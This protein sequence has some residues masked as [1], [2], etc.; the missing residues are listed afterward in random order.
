MS[1]AWCVGDHEEEITAA[2]SR[3]NSE[4]QK[5]IESASLE[6]L[7]VYVCYIFCKSG[8]KIFTFPLS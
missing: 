6:Y 5:L 8:N 3:L 1:V 2:L 7:S 4:L